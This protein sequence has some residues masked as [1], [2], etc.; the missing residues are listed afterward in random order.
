MNGGISLKRKKKS[1]D[2]LITPEEFN[3][4]IQWADMVGQLAQVKGELR[5]MLNGKSDAEIRANLREYES[6]HTIDGAPVSEETYQVLN[7]ELIRRGPYGV[8]L[9]PN[10]RTNQKIL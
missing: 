7:A 2:K 6:H 1:K 3:V 8:L 5:M 9:N 4:A 10:N